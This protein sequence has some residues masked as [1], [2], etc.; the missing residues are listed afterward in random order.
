MYARTLYV[1]SSSSEQT[2]PR[3]IIFVSVSL[4]LELRSLRVFSLTDEWCR[5]RGAARRAGRRDGNGMA[6]VLHMPERAGARAREMLV[7]IA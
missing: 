2:P 4:S 3:P 1:V 6:V 5:R 7:R